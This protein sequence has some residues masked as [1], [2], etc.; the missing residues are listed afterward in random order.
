MTAAV[1]TAAERF[2]R[3][4]EDRIVLP[5]PLK[6]WR[7]VSKVPRVSGHLHRASS[8]SQTLAWVAWIMA[9][10]SSGKTARS[11]SKPLPASWVQP[12][13]NRTVSMAVSKAASL[14]VFMAASLTCRRP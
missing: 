7:R 8:L 2:W 6:P 12:A 11:R 13:P 4:P 1:T 14:V 10:A 9:R 5:K 3:A